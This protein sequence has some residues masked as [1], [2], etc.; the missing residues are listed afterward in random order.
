MQRA[1]REEE[2][3]SEDLLDASDGHPTQRMVELAAEA[4][5]EVVLAQQ[6]PERSN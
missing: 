4:I 2:L 1:S 6:P 3:R 5:K